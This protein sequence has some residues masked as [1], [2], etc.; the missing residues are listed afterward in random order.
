M[1]HPLV[2]LVAA[3][4]ILQY[5]VFGMLVGRARE[6][7]G[8]R[9]PAISGDEIF[10]RHY[11][12]QMNT[13]ELLIALLPLLY[14]AAHYWSAGWVAA[15]GAL[16]LIGRTLYALAYVRDP[17][18]RGLGFMLSIAPIMIL[19]IMALFGTARALLA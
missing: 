18:S 16:Y 15:L 17:A 9:A 7:T 19:L 8:L 3:L 2:D 14:A 12:V 5:L 6:K 13:L 10:E 11:R 1:T 4:A